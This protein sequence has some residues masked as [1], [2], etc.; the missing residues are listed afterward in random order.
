MRPNPNDTLLLVIDIQ[1]RLFAAMPEPDRTSVLARA[2]LAVDGAALLGVQ[3]IATE[4]Y[5][6]GLGPTVS[7]L[8][9]A[10]RGAGAQIIE[11]TSFSAMDEDAVRTAVD[12]AHKRHVV[13]C[14]METHICVLQ[15][16]RDLRALG[17]E[18][19]LLDDAVLSRHAADRRV[20]LEA[21]RQL[22]A[23]TSS[24]ES[25]LF[26]WLHVAQGAAFK[27]ISKRVRALEPW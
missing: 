21:I 8:G 9:D 10:L 22:G 13:V 7:P 1:D 15:T 24:V 19:A 6:K 12:A 25:T 2:T 14:G 18:V 3:T 11:K 5:P 16:V 20:G 17:H 23:R 26:D 27:A 4:Q